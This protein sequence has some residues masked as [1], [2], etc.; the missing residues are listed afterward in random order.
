MSER[1]L[2]FRVQDLGFRGLGSWGLEF[3]VW[4]FGFKGLGIRSRVEVA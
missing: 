2:G 1:D 4:S 3:R